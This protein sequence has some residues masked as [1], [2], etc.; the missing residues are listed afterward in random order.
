MKRFFA[1]ILLLLLT[2]SL[3]AQVKVG[4]T[5]KVGGTVKTSVSTGGGGGGGTASDDFNRANGGL[6]A[7]WTTVFDFG[8]FAI[9]TNQVTSSDTSGAWWAG[10]G[11]FT[12]DQ[13]SQIT[14]VTHNSTA[15]QGAGVR[16]SGTS[17][18]TTK[19]YFCGMTSSSPQTRVKL[20]KMNADATFTDIVNDIDAPTITN[21]DV[22]KL[23]V[24]FSGGVNTLTCTRNGSGV[25]PLTGVT[26]STIGTGGKPGFLVG[27]A[28]DTWSAGAP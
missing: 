8:S 24:T 26:D 13:Y 15:A 4:G 9:N 7:N 20:F 12:D 14:I 6:G 2:V 27:T 10:A 11:S 16:M 3:P 1:L 21:G 23:S 5:A 28:V 18:V 25:T 22:L 19:G 17:F